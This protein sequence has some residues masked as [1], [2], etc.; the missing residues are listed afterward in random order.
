[1]YTKRAPGDINIYAMKDDLTTKELSKIEKQRLAN[2]QSYQRYKEERKAYNSK[3]YQANREKCIEL[4]V[5]NYN[6]VRCKELYKFKQS[7]LS[8][9]EKKQKSEER[10]LR[11]SLRSSEEIQKQKERSIIC[12]ANLSPEKIQQSKDYHKRRYRERKEAIVAYNKKYNKK[13]EIIQRRKERNRT[14]W[15]TD[16]NFKIAGIL[17]DRLHKGLKS[18][19]IRKTIS[20]VKLI[21]CTIEQLKKHI[22]SQFLLGMSWKNYRH[23]TW[24][25]DH[26]KPC[27]TFDLTDPIQQRQ[28]FHYTNLRPLWAKDNLSRPKNGSDI[29]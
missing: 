12:K 4:A 21:G 26:I 13:E 23:D 27:N 18:K 10:K 17:R 5:L 14:R 22:E 19:G 24:H 1:M 6:P 7:K 25:I 15:K 3:Y 9:D 2:R 29:A 11:Y 20:A 28:C 16:L 8:I